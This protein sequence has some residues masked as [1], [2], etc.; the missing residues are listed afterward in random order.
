MTKVNAAGCRLASRQRCDP[1]DLRAARPDDRCDMGG[2]LHSGGDTVRVGGARSC[3]SSRHAGSAPAF[4]ISIRMTHH[5][6]H[7]HEEY[8]AIDLLKKVF[9]NP[10][11]LMFAFV[12]LTA[13]VLRN[14]IMQ[15]YTIFAHEVKQPGAE[16]ILGNWGLLLCVFG[17]VGGF[18]GGLD[19]RQILPVT[20]RAARCDLL[21][22]HA[23]DG[24]GDGDESLFAAVRRRCRRVAH[25]RCGDRSAFIDVGH[26]GGG[27]RRP[28]GDRD[29]RQASWMDSFILEAACNQSVSVILLRT[30]AGNGGRSSLCRLRSSVD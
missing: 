1:R 23:H 21:R 13:G 28:Q 20:P 19:L 27:F 29:L 24:G 17:I 26:G 2:I 7:M 30:T 15:W 9:L 18:A 5:R 6:G 8:S 10:L 11:M 12:E 16:I 4:P 25:C 14:G 22:V 3:G